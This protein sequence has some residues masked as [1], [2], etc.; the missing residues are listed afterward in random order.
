MPT[1]FEIAEDKDLSL[2][3]FMKGFVAALL[4]KGAA[5][6]RP[7]A[8]EDR[9]ALRR[10]VDLLEN[11]IQSSR[12]TPQTSAANKRWLRALVRIRNELQPSPVGAFDGFE[13]A[14]RNLQLSVTNCPNPFYEE[15]AFSASRPFAEATLKDEFEVRERQ[16]LEHLAD[17]FLN[18]RRSSISA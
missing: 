7:K 6:I 8:D 17:G 18:C 16:L 3:R 2:A 9:D 1:S 5:S 11:E 10:V 4:T 15:I 13:A 14:L 12:S